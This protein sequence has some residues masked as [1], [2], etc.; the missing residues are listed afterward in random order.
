MG[1]EEAT[2]TDRGGGELPARVERRGNTQMTDGDEPANHEKDEE[3][4]PQCKFLLNSRVKV[5]A[6]KMK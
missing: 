5:V 3:H 4:D 1:K 2:M 6:N